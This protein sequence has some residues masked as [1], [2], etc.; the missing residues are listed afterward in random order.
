MTSCDRTMTG[1]G[2]SHQ[3]SQ[4]AST[5]PYDTGACHNW[6]NRTSI[7]TPRQ[8]LQLP[9]RI[10]VYF[11]K[12]QAWHL[13]LTLKRAKAKVHVPFTFVSSNYFPYRF[14]YIGLML[15]KIWNIRHTW[16]IWL[17]L[18]RKLKYLLTV[19]NYGDV[20]ML[21]DSV[22]SDSLRPYGL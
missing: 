13:S 7:L 14:Y 19:M 20:C 11:C 16:N 12:P 1:K 8:G 18:N 9:H 5:Q 10:K 6:D 4:G 21:T 15:W 2:Q 17:S 22:V 3:E